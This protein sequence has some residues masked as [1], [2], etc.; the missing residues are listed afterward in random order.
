MI[1]IL[2]LL[3]AV[4][5]AV[6]NPDE[7]LAEGQESLVRKLQRR[8]RRS[9]R[10]LKEALQREKNAATRLIQLE[11]NEARQ[12]A[13][14]DEIDEKADALATRTGQLEERATSTE[15][16]LT[17]DSN[18]LDSL[19]VGGSGDRSKCATLAPNTVTSQALDPGA[20]ITN[21]NAS[22]S[23]QPKIGLDHVENGAELKTVAQQLQP[24]AQETPAPI[25]SAGSGAVCPDGTELRDITV[26]AD[27][28]LTHPIVFVPTKLVYCAP[29]SPQ[30]VS[31]ASGDRGGGGAPSPSGPSVRTD[32]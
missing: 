20:A 32:N 1:A 11:T 29:N 15:E 6:S 3:P 26:L 31:E 5:N 4:S 28:P 27:D 2:M 24:D 18:R 7:R 19:C 21:I 13:R 8:I 22:V 25:P 9:Q 16:A 30:A 10:E 17:E 23:G 12:D 14:A